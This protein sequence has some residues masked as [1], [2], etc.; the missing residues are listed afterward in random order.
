MP[1]A[2]LKQAYILLSVTRSLSCQAI[3][4]TIVQK[5]AMHAANAFNL[6]RLHSRSF[7]RRPCSLAVALTL[8]LTAEVH[9]SVDVDI[10]SS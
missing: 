10:R 6:N 2:C 1:S 3:V 4:S 7:S 5:V 9:I 8:I